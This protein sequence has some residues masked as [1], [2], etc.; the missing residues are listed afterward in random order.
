MNPQQQFQLLQ[1]PH[2]F[3]FAAPQAPKPKKKGNFLTSLIPSGGGIAGGAAGAAIGT[4]LLPGIGTLIGAGL[5]SA[6]GGGGGKVAENAIEHNKLTS[7][8][9]GEAAINGLLGVGPLRAGKVAID[10]ARGLKAGTGLADAI[11]N[12]GGNA[13]KMSAT[14]AVGDKLA[15]SGEGLIAKEFRLNPTQQANFKKLT[16]EEAVSV[17]RRYGIKKPE[18]IQ[19]KIQPLQDAFDS[20]VKQIPSVSKTEL[21]TGLEKVYK[22]LMNSPAL[23]EQGLGK[24][25]KDQAAELLKAAKGGSLPAEQVNK[26][27]QVFDNAVNYTQKGAPEYNVIKKTADALRGTLQTAADKAGVKTV[28]GATFKNAG[29]ELRKLRNLDEVIGKQSYLGT[30]SLPLNLPTL[31]GA[32]GGGAAFGGPAGSA[33][34]GLITA[35]ANSAPG[36]RAITNGVLK[37]GEKLASKGAKAK[38]FGITGITG[39]LAPAG[40]IGAGANML[41]QS[42]NSQPTTASAPNST[43]APMNANISPLN[44]TNGN[45]SSPDSPFAPQNLESAIQKILS[46]GGTPADAK[47][48][49]DLAGAVQKLQGAGQNATPG[50]SK[51][52]A[53]QYAQGV[54]GEQSIAQLQQLLQQNPGLVSKNAIP[55]QGV[56]VIGGLLSGALGTSDYRAIT[57]NIL[58]SIARINTG[59]NMPAEEEAFY[60]KTYLPQPGDSPQTQQDKIN[61]LES[62]FTPITQYPGSSGGSDTTDLTSALLAAQGLQ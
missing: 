60:R 49:V 37:T 12:A 17:L 23:F 25:I 57:H 15:K 62:F 35:I 46:N 20:V 43:I 36:R 40:V 51:P 58:N 21:Q 27:R 13:V 39:R 29:L 56:G 42:D 54:A 61:A 16:G 22:P 24:Q 52:T 34:A 38:P 3:T 48:F 59:A 19:A 9:A 41:N 33:G 8:V 53:S 2:Q 47:A 26:L 28:E 4:A 6:I 44:Q 50:Y 7:G 5:G 11:V 45:M 1:A 14:K 31:L 18:D 55:G 30:G 32:A 10:T